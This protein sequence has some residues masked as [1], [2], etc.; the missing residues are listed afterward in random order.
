MVVWDGSAKYLLVAL[1]SIQK[2][3]KRLFVAKLQTL[4]HRR[5]VVRLS[6]YSSLNCT[7]TLTSENHSGK[8]TIGVEFAKLVFFFL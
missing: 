7:V 6:V 8:V 5:R 1:D 4:E 2:R 3:D